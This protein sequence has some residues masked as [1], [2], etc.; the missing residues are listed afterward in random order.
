MVTSHLPDPSPSC[1]DSPLT[2]KFL[3]F[4][5][6]AAI[7]RL[8]RPP[9]FA[10]PPL[11]SYFC[12]SFWALGRAV[13]LIFHSPCSRTGSSLLQGLP[14]NYQVPPLLAP[15]LSCT[16]RLSG[17]CA[18]RPFRLSPLPSSFG[19]CAGC[20]P[21]FFILL[22]L[23][24]A[25]CERLR[26]GYNICWPFRTLS[27][28][29]PPVGPRPNNQVSPFSRLSCNGRLSGACAGRPFRLCFFEG[30]CTGGFS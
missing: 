29:L 19:A 10:P 22:P 8:R 14:P 30:A 26:R 6:W 28:L 5:D 24:V 18:G 21:A 2:I 27:T 16:G 13:S 4:L 9:F 1:R 17:A 7:R 3:P 20:L 23:E 15:L 12:I 11:P 25:L